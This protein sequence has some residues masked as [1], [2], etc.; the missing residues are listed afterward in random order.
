MNAKTHEPLDKGELHHER[1]EK[2]VE[3]RPAIKMYIDNDDPLVAIDRNTQ[4]SGH[5]W[6]F[7]VGLM[8]HHSVTKTME[9]VVRACSAH[10]NYHLH[11]GDFLRPRKPK[12]SKTF[13]TLDNEEQAHQAYLDSTMRII[14][15]A[16]EWRDQWRPKKH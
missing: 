2:C 7:S 12:V 16:V 8:A 3:T 9:H 10:S 4:C 11:E 1:C 14:G 15:D 5:V 6:D 13:G